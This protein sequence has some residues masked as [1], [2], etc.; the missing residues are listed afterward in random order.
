MYFLMKPFL[1]DMSETFTVGSNVCDKSH[2]CVIDQE[3]RS[4]S[5]IS[6]INQSTFHF[7]LNIYS[8]IKLIQLIS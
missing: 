7:I 8:C 1:A 5:L 6:A 3:N 4:L 2:Q